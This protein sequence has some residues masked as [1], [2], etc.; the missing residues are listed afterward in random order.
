MIILVL[1][2]KWPIKYYESL[3]VVYCLC[4][5]ETVYAYMKCVRC[6]SNGA[7]IFITASRTMFALDTFV[8]SCSN[9]MTEFKSFRCFHISVQ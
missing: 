7:V 2:L 1:T 4:S 5:I 6:K 3:L 9:V 8:S